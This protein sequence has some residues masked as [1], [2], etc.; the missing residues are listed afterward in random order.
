MK[1]TPFAE[2]WSWQGF[3]ASGECPFLEKPRANWRVSSRLPQELDELAM[4]HIML[5]GI[6]FPDVLNADARFILDTLAKRIL[7][8]EHDEPRI[9]RDDDLLFADLCH[10]EGDGLESGGAVRTCGRD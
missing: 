6:W 8:S 2:I 10:A 1:T 5:N 9:D 3:N 7:K 4:H